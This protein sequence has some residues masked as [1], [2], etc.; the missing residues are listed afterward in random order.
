MSSTE[1]ITIGVI[2]VIGALCLYYIFKE[3]I[4]NLPD[5]ADVYSI[6][7]L[8]ERIKKD[9]NEIINTDLTALRLNKKDLEN[10]REM[11]RALSYAVR[12]CSQGD[13]TA[14]MVVLKKDKSMLA[15]TYKV[16][17]DVID[18]ILPFNNPDRLTAQDMFEILMYLQKR[19]GNRNMFR[20]ICNKV[21]F[22]KLKEDAEGYYYAIDEEDV[23]TA[24]WKLCEPLSYDDKLNIL[25]QRI[26]QETHGLSVVD[27]FVME[28]DSIDGVQ[29][30]VS[31]VTK[32]D[33]RYQEEDIFFG[34]Y[35][36]PKAYESVWLV[37]A[38][39]LIHLKF[40]S[41]QTNT[42]IIRI[43]KNLAEYGRTGHITSSE[44]GTK[45][46]LADG[47]RVTIFRPN[48][49]S[50]WAFFVRKF[51]SAPSYQLRDLIQDK[52]KELPIELIEWG[53][54]GCLNLIFTGD[55]NSGKTTNT[56]AA[57]GGIDRRQSVRTIEA[58]FELYLNDAYHNKNILGV[59]PSARMNFEKVIEL[60][61]ASDAH[62]ILFGETASLEHAKHAI[63]LLLAGTKRVIMTG[64]WPTSDEMVS[65]F[66]LAMGAY[67]GAGTE[68][69]EALVARLLHLDI[70]C[71]KENDGHRHI[72]RITEIIPISRDLIIPEFG[73]GIEA[74]LG[75]IGFYL[76][77]QTR[78]K[79][80]Y[81]RDLIVFEAGEYRL[82][83]NLSDRL[84]SI[85]L[86]NL[87][88]EERAKFLEFNMLR[89]EKTEAVG[90]LICG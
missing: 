37:Y 18:K 22:D 16:T 11:N 48:N 45:T 74:R 6:Q 87:A 63:N 43:C 86:K 42:T 77:E 32:D 15:N 72:D 13:I 54:K 78:K 89:H 55:Q 50:Q 4:M 70:H 34:N 61:K 31:G 36:K 51:G 80:Y 7:Y 19:S 9:I 3:E 66:V 64:H 2:L 44:G 25:T 49:S 67:G 46:H 56:R 40:L 28:D 12:S 10:R 5:N 38:G 29:G 24:Y 79:T 23:L 35:S 27:M 52:G 84:A 41:F 90:E 20:G 82:L 65:Y 68:D 85:V 76:K 21:E 17:E 73:K 81:T 58:D 83:H 14:K 8:C 60:L 26:Y 59:R 47:S 69:V 33:F 57:S 62:T 71:V 53:T 88:P 1:G 39:K 75:E 30:G